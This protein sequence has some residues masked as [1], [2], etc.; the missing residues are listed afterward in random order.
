MSEI[1]VNVLPLGSSEC[2]FKSLL[3]SPV[4]APRLQRK[5]SDRVAL[6][7]LSRGLLIDPQLASYRYSRPHQA[8]KFHEAV[9]VGKDDK[10]EKLLDFIEQ[11]R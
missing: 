8:Y 3:K 10:L 4:R 7:G 2:L 11:G 9:L 6:K 5:S 1:H